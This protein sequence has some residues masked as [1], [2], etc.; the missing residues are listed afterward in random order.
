[1]VST[2]IEGLSVPITVAMYAWNNSNSILYNGIF[3]AANCFTSMLVSVLLVK[4]SLSNVN[5]RK[6]ILTGQLVFCLF[7]IFTYPWKFYGE[8]LPRP[9]LANGTE[10]LEL[11]GGCSRVY[12]WCE[13]TAPIPKG[14]YI[15]TFILGLGDHENRVQCKGY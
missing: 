12:E 2:T 4:T 3:M 5:S 6:L 14:I 13:A 15:A 7:F 9:L 11:F 10:N 1:M 8:N